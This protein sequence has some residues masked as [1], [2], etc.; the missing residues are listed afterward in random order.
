[1]E[2][3]GIVLNSTELIEGPAIAAW[4]DWFKERPVVCPG[5]FDFPIIEPGQDRS[6]ENAEV[7]SF[8][9]KALNK[10]G[11]NSVIYVCALPLLSVGQ[12][13]KYFLQVSFGSL[14]WST[15]P[16]KIW[17]VL[18]ILMERGIPFVSRP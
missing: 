11:P 16:E 14:W 4:K 6:D 13:S 17:A 12:N 18:D 9:D 7:I 5:P 2:C 8:L 3:N 15:E 1:M 10:Y